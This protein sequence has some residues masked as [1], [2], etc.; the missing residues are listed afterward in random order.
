MEAQ[1]SKALSPMYRTLAGMV[2]FSK[3]LQFRKAEPSILVTLSGSAIC[4]RPVQLLKALDMIVSSVEPGWKV[5]LVRLPHSKKAA[6]IKVTVDGMVMPSKLSQRV[7]A[8]GPVQ[9]ESILVTPSNIKTFFILGFP[10]LSL[11]SMVGK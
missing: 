7:K 10:R 9:K 1:P 4:F 6:L 5:T 2:T 3:A 8:P 11:E